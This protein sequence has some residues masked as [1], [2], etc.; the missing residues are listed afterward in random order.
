ME[1]NLD[2]V[3]LEEETKPG[4]PYLKEFVSKRGTP[5]VGCNGTHPLFWILGNYPSLK[6][7]RHKA[8]LQI[9]KFSLVR[10]VRS[11]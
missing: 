9:N 2:E 4:Q 8:N 11:C 3:V 7:F 1:L 10:I 5:S 6:K